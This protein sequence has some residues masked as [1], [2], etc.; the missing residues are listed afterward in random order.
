MSEEA[1]VIEEHWRDVVATAREFRA[2]RFRIVAEARAHR[3]VARRLRDR[4]LARR[5]RYLEVSWR[6][7]SVGALPEP[8]SVIPLSWSLGSGPEPELEA[9]FAAAEECAGVSAAAVRRTHDAERRTLAAISGVCRFV[10]DCAHASDSDTRTA[11]GLCVRVIESNAA[12]LDKIGRTEGGTLAASAA[13]RCARQCS[14]ALTA[15]YLD[16]ED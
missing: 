2:T 3:R 5:E 15:S 8:P 10:A 12:V 1:H 13:R 16:V 11:L 14:R 6:L 7:W 9:A 4:S